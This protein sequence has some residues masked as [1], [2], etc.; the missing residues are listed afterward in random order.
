MISEKENFLLLLRGQMPEFI[1]T[2]RREKWLISG[3][4]YKFGDT[5]NDEGYPVDEYGVVYTTTEESMGGIMPLPG[6]VLLDDITRW[7]DVIR[8][9]DL[10]SVDWEKYAAETLASRDTANDPVIVYHGHFFI[11]LV[12]FMSFS[13]ALIVLLEEPEECC[14]LMEYLCDYHV[15]LFKKQIRYLKPD[16]LALSDDISSDRSPFISLDIY[17]RIIKPHHKRLADIALDNNMCVMMHCC[18]NAEPFLDDFVD[19]GVSGWEPAQA[20][21]DFPTIKKKFGRKLAIMGGWDNTG[22]F[23]LPGTSDEELRAALIEYVDTF[24]PGGG[25]AYMGRVARSFDEEDYKRKSAIC[26]EVYETYARDW[27]KTHS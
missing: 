21:N 12:N 17:R 3:G 1:S 9:P 19:I 10:S 25:F 2:Y 13:E 23:S 20:G 26:E 18:G 11:K 22:R 15:E 7:R 4:P 16:I 8:N 5:K 24:A 6:R 14:A 27:Y